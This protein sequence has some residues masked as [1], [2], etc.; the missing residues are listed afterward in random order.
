MIIKYSIVIPT[1]NRAEYLSYAIKSVLNSKRS[2][3]E[4]IVSN[5]FSTDKTQEILSNISDPRIKIISPNVTLPMAGH[6]EFA[7][8]QAKGEWITILGD[9]DAVMPYIFESLDKY[10]KKYPNIDIISSVRAYYFWKGCEDVNGNA[11]VRYQSNFKAQLRS[12]RKDLISVLKGL[13]ICFNMPQIY[14]TCMVRRS[15]YEEIKVK[16]GGCFY[17]SI[18][19]DMYSVV[20]LCLS[21]NKYLR[22]EEPL[23][24]VGTS[25]KSLGRSDRIYK[26]AEKFRDDIMGKHICVPKKISSYVSY[27]LHSSSFSPYFIFECLLQSPLNSEMYSSKKIKTIV[28]AAVMNISKKREKFEKISLKKEIYLECNRYS[29]SSKSLFFTTCKLQAEKNLLFLIDLPYR[30][31]RK[32]GLLS[33]WVIRSNNRQKY[34]T[35][36]SASDAVKVL[37]NKKL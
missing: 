27:F 26:D 16:S 19:P 6:Y 36:L 2:D 32:I 12:T 37:L 22:V 1:R 25:N 5:N 8:S 18:I 15:L 21:R 14:T 7:I 29:I 24:W 13:R 28:L 10:I 3:I 11:V 30:I 34:L 31:L 4:L 23:F 17:H 33:P 20:A 9:D 35:I